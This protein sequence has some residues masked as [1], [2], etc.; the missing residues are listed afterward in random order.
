MW[1]DGQTA[2]TFAIT[3]TETQSYKL[4]ILLYLVH[5]KMGNKQ[6]TT[7]WHFCGERRTAKYYLL[8]FEAVCPF[9][10]TALCLRSRYEPPEAQ[11]MKKSRA[12]F[13]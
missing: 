2:D 7:L 9:S 11:L 1:T 8:R 5:K 13:S 12:D 6:S 3:E 4:R 10:G